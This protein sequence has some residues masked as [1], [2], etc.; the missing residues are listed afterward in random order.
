MKRWVIAF[1]TALTFL[2]SLW[3]GQFLPK[4][5]AADE[6]P[7]VHHIILFDLKPTT[8]E[9]DLAAM[10]T[11]AKDLLAKI[12]GVLELEM[13]RKAL[14]NR[15]VHIKDYDVGLYIKLSKLSDLEVYILSP[16]HQEFIRRNRFKWDTFKMIDFY[17]N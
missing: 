12:P 17:G 10:M 13:G 1:A 9:S 2:G 7:P 8:S 11:D 14:D 16:Q 6:N 3:I 15:D 5:V 4:A